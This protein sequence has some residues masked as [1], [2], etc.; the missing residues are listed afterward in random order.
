MKRILRTAAAFILRK[1]A[2]DAMTEAQALAYQKG[3][4]SKHYKTIIGLVDDVATVGKTLAEA[5]KDPEFT[6]EERAKC[7]DMWQRISDRLADL[8]SD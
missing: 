7:H 4:D 1:G 5:G 3:K 8:I 2:A 6:S